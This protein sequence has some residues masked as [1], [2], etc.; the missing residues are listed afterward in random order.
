M[1]R[2][3]KIAIIVIAL[4]ILAGV[5][6][7]SIQ[8]FSTTAL[9]E[10]YL[11]EKEDRLVYAKVLSEQNE[12]S[13]EVT[14]SKV[15]T[16]NEVPILKSK[17][18]VYTGSIDGG[19]LILK[20][21][22]GVALNAVVNLDE[23]VVNGPWLGGEGETRL[24]A[25]DMASY[26]KKR[27]AMTAL[28]NEQ[29]EQKKKELA[30]KK[31]KEE[32]RVQFAK[33]VERT[34][35]LQA[36]ILENVEYLRELQ[37]SDES[38]VFQDQ[39]VELQALLGEIT[40]YG[41]QPSLHKA[42]FEVM[43]QMAGSMKVLVDGMNVLDANIETK[44]KKMRDIIAVMETDFADTKTSWEAVK[45][46]LPEPEKSAKAYN[47]AM[48]AGPQAVKEAKERIAAIDQEQTSAKAKAAKLYEQA[49]G[50]LSRTK[51]KH[52]F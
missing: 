42:E 46:R 26:E 51:A 25:S 33:Q 18:I 21:E 6:Y 16:E 30:E 43:H 45:D 4:V 36:D 44:K 20:Q 27:E 35:K 38:Q 14:D 48:K 50:I 37:F 49:N 17:T 13:L 8:F 11:Y 10:G 7:A 23:L 9:A 29:A 41:E 28:V 3:N 15:E 39:L 1:L 22:S 19:N 32:E 34:Q 52:H 40:T 24:A 47:E 31:A 12:I 2:K 5:G